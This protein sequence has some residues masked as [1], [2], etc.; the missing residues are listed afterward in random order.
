MT[1]VTNLKEEIKMANKDKTGP[2]GNGPMT[3][4]GMG[5]CRN[6]ANID[7]DIANRQGRHGYYNGNRCRSGNHRNMGPHFGMNHGLGCRRNYS[8]VRSEDYREGEDLLLSK[9]AL[10]HH[11]E[12]L[13]VK[14]NYIND[15]LQKED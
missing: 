13:E 1:Y 5:F 4:R 7:E 9:E 3:G 11:K 10:E 6:N 12:I 14:L 2:R 15:Q 8:N